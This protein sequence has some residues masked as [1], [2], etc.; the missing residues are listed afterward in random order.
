MPS[1]NLGVRAAPHNRYAPMGHVALCLLSFVIAAAAYAD[2][3]VEVD[4]EAIEAANR[5]ARREFGERLPK[6]KVTKLFRIDPS[7]TRRNAPSS[8]SRFHDWIVVASAAPSDDPSATTI[9]RSLAS[10]VASHDSGVAAC[11]DPHH[12]LTLSDGGT[13]FD[14]LLCFEC[15]RYIVYT[16]GGAVMYADSFTAHA[17]KE[18]WE[19]VFASAGLAGQRR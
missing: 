8:A 7:A 5:A 10:I 12:G 15:S 3:N 1:S 13:S 16:S 9:S 18:T 2:R 14:V 4:W 17:E 6:L 19:Q 11:F